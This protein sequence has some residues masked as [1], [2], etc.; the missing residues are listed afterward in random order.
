MPR[1]SGLILLG[2]SLPAY[3]LAQVTTSQ[4]DNSRSG[5]NL[6]ETTLTARNVNADH[7][8][9]LFSLRVDGDVYA[10]PLYLPGVEIQGKGKHDVV[11]VATEHDSVYAFDAQGEPRTPLWHVN[12]TN[13]EQGIT[14]VDGRDVQCPFINPEV[15]ITSTPVIDPG[16]GT[17]YVL[18]RTKSGNKASGFHY[19]QRLHAI[20]V[21]SGAERAGSPVDVHASIKGSGSAGDIN[22]DPLI[23]NPR[24]ALLLAGGTY[25]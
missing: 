24:S 7:F 21:T 13:T 2:A 18:A 10:Q 1:L 4:Y 22:F 11:F 19:I 6:H 14:T 9:R 17:L 8:G 16:T 23:E 25:I 20:D 12:F 3:C 5:A 15:G